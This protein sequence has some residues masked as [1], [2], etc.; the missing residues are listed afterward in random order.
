[1]DFYLSLVQKHPIYMAMLKFALLGTLGEFVSKWV[2]NKKFF[3]PFTI[4]TI[5]WKFVVWGIL[6]ICIQ[7]AFVGIFG[8]IDSLID[9]NYLPKIFVENKFFR[10]FG[11]SVLINLQFGMFLVLFHRVLD[12]IIVK[13]KNWKGLDKGLISLLW[14]WI[15][16]HTITFTLPKDL[17]TLMAAGLS[18]VLGLI[19]GFF[20][21]PK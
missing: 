20:N 3:N 8:F 15:P 2:I 14:F 5:L 13:E 12:N 6:G 17:R 19:L 1:M 16:A 9:S 18:V 10:A 21:R 4:K 7:Y 11:V